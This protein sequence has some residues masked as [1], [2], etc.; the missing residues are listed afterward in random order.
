MHTLVSDSLPGFQNFSRSWK[1]QGILVPPSGQKEERQTS[2]SPI[3]LGKVEAGQAGLRA[4]PAR[5]G[6]PLYLE[7]MWEAGV[8]SENLL[9]LP[10]LVSH[11]LASMFFASV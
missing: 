2:D 7:S 8:F 11:I 6:V 1:T 4:Q 10:G 3:D 5:V 9:S